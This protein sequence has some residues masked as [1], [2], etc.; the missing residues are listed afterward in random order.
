MYVCIEFKRKI[1]DREKSFPCFFDNLNWS[2]KL[3]WLRPPQTAE[4]NE[5]RKCLKLT[6]LILIQ[7]VIG[8]GVKVLLSFTVQKIK[9]FIWRPTYCPVLPCKFPCVCWTKS[10]ASEISASKKAKLFILFYLLSLEFRVLHSCQS[11]HWS[12]TVVYRYN[13]T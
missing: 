4:S 5:I 12:G 8:V 11:C 2:V 7:S 9:S 13:R 3:S 1:F 6:S 10:Y